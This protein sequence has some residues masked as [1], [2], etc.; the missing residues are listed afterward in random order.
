MKPNFS[1]ASEAFLKS[2]HAREWVLRRCPKARNH[3]TPSR[4]WEVRDGKIILGKSDYLNTTAW[5][6]AAI[7]IAAAAIGVEIG[8]SVDR[9]AVALMEA[10]V[11]TVTVPSDVEV[12]GEEDNE[13]GHCLGSGKMLD[14]LDFRRDTSCIECMGS[15]EGP[16]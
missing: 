15:G 14:P 10:E 2:I 6:N 3:R 13:C 9:K 16:V 8:G 5:E 1:P 7:R 12:D 4:G 11:F